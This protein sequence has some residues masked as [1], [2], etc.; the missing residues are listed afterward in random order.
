MTKKAELE[1]LQENQREYFKEDKRAKKAFDKKYDKLLDKIDKNEEAIKNTQSNIKNLNTYKSST[2]KNWVKE[3]KRIIWPK[4]SKAW[5]W[6]GITVAFAVGAAI[7]CFLVTLGFTSLWNTV[8][9][10]N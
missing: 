10:K 9:I 2:L 4:S 5:K 6:F 7:F 3:I 1:Q 8:G